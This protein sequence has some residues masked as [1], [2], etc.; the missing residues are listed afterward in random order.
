LDKAA[1]RRHLRELRKALPADVRDRANRRLGQH[2]AVIL[3]AL[4][5]PSRPVAL[6]APKGSEASP[7]G[8]LPLPNP[9][10]WPR[11][12]TLSPPRLTFHLAPLHRLVEG[13]LRIREPAAADPQVRPD[14]LAAIVVPLLGFDD[15]GYRLGQGGGFYDALIASLPSDETQ[16]PRLIGL[17]FSCQRVDELP[18]EPH[19]Q[20]VDLVLTEDGPATSSPPT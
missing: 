11:V 3:R 15:R 18:R 7:L 12:H 1:L 13:T 8:A 14:E 6:Y 4:N 5:A 16:R 20:P 17:A 2:L 10:A 9:I 19:D